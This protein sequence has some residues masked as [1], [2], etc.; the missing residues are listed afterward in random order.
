MR[1]L[2]LLL[3]AAWPWTPALPAPTPPLS[4]EAL[5]QTALCDNPS[6]KAA[7]ARWEMM[8]QRVP[9]AR[10]WEDL[11]AG[12]NLERMGTLRP[13]KINDVEWMISQTIPIS[14]KNLSQAR[15]SVAEALAAYQ[16]WRRVQL[17]VVLR[18]NAAYYRLAGA[19]GQL[20]I[21][22]RTQDLLKQLVQLSRTKYETGTATQSDVLLAETELAR[23]SETR[24]TLERDR[25]DQQT[26]LN[27]L[28]NR[29]ASRPVGQPAPLAF[30]GSVLSADKA[31]ELASHQRPEILIAWRKIEAEQARLQLA[32]RQW[33]PDP[34]LIIAARQY[35]GSQGV[36][37]YDTGITFSLPWANPKKYRAGVAEAAAS[38]ENARNEYDAAR[39]EAAGMVR[40]Q[41]TKITT[42]ATNTRL[43]R[44]KVTPMAKSTVE[45]T[46]AGYETDKSGFLDLITASR[47]LQEIESAGLNQLVEHQIAIAE[48]EAI[49]GIG[50]SPSPDASK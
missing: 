31:T 25:S 41:L 17:D 43:Y 27:V 35:P 29:P 28:A 46:R 4:K 16:E 36:Q 45:S 49:V 9:Q 1:R 30:R 44:E 11:M 22:D 39:A 50:N 38:L 32:H 48:L 10:A 14:G 19:Y 33:I 42:F 21:N 12:V 5:L 15:A 20:E 24:S 2:L 23:L 18:V 7:R 37:E 8:K 34:K 26:Q 47:N 40:D 13:D 3:L 6:L